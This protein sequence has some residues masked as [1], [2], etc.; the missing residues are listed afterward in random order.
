MHYYCRTNDVSMLLNRF[1]RGPF[2]DMDMVCLA[3]VKP[4]AWGVFSLTASLPLGAGIAPAGTKP[5]KE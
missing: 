3:D 5:V 4:A 2:G 1:I